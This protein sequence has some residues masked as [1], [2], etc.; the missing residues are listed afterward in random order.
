VLDRG[1]T[2]TQVP[3]AVS[4]RTDAET[5]QRWIMADVVLAALSPA[6]Y[7]IEVVISK[8]SSETRLLTP[9]RVGR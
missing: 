7:V 5:G 9:I 6:D 2:A 3:V 1:G 4:E 8:E